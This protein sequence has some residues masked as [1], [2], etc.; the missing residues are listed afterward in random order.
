M[1]AYTHIYIRFTFKRYIYIKKSPTYANL[2]VKKS[3]S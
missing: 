2:M 1:I 3:G